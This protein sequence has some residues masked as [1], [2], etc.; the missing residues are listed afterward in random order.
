LFFNGEDCSLESELLE[1]C[2]NLTELSFYFFYDQ[3]ENQ[4]QD[5]NE[6]LIPFTSIRVISTNLVAYANENGLGTIFLPEGTYTIGYHQEA[7]PDWTLTT[8]ELTYEVTIDPDFPPTSPLVFGLRPLVVKSELIT[9]LSAPPARCDRFIDFVASAKNLGTTIADGTLWLTIDENIDSV[10]WVDTPDTIQPPNRYGWLFTELFPGHQ[11]NRTIQLKIPGP[12]D[13]PLGD[14][15]V[16]NTSVDYSDS[17]GMQQ[18]DPFVYETEVRCSFDPNDKLVHPAR[19]GNYTLFDET[20]VYTVRFQNTGN[21]EAYDVVIRDT[22]DAFLEANSFRVIGTSHPD[23]LQTTLQE[24]GYLTF[25]FPNIFLPD[26]T[27]DLEGSQGYITY[28]IRGQEGLEEMTP[29]E[30]TASIYFDTNPAVVTNTTENIMVSVIPT[31]STEEV[32]TLQAQ[33][34]LLPNPNNGLVTLDGLNLAGAQI[35]IIDLAGQLLHQQVLD[36]Q[37]TL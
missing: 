30:N 14:Y 33:I 32:A 6:P 12:L 29:I 10:N 16:L 22:L 4:I 11:I 23:I 13:F 24:G 28:L 20:L 31:V 3:N 15:L 8:D 27:S 2:A 35:R 26:S 34:Q 25:N 1:A 9:C 5:S 17:N 7:T 37:Q 18:S 21:A 19:E 36:A